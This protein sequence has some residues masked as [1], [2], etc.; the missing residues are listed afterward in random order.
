MNFRSS[1][2]YLVPSWLSSGDGGKV[3]GSLMLILDIYIQ[4]AQSGLLARFPSYAGPSALDLI[5]KDRGIPRG[6]TETAKHY[7]ARLIG[8]RWPLGHRVRGNA[9]AL[10]EQVSEY[11][12]GLADW[13]IDVRGNFYQRSADGSTESYTA[14]VPWNWDNVPVSPRWGRFWLGIVPQPTVAITSSPAFGSSALWPGG[15]GGGA[16][17]GLVGLSPDDADAI[18]GLF[19]GAHP[20][21][22]AGVR[23]QWLIVDLDGVFVSPNGAWDQ[24]S[25]NVAGVQVASRYDGWRYISLYPPNLVYSGD[26]TNFP[27]AATLVDGTTYGGDRTIFEA[28]VTL[29]SGRVYAGNANS[30][31]VGVTLF[32][33]GDPV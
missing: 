13:T 15:Y 11:F 3:L 2:K 21:K 5:G 27:S 28:S 4:R 1:F 8:W 30:F 29:P 31:P 10:L 14:G 23:P 33:D 19:T 7:A 20:W 22:P 12:G 24:W 16:A 6:R 26:P 18:R 25:E 17:I 32:D 9:Y